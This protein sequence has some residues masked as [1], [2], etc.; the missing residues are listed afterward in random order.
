I[1]SFEVGKAW[2]SG[3]AGDRR[4]LVMKA[5]AMPIRFRGGGSDPGPLSS[6]SKRAKRA[7]RCLGEE[8]FVRMVASDRE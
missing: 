1:V 3:A 4:R 2:L 7:K 8:S 6:P 5:V